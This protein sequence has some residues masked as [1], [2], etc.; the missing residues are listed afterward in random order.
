MSSKKKER[1]FT[2]TIPS[3]F[4]DCFVK[5]YC[6]EYKVT[7]VRKRA[8]GP[9]YVTGTWEALAKKIDRITVA[10]RVWYTIL[11]RRLE[12]ACEVDTLKILAGMK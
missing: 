8:K 1:T 4:E 11:M 5:G 6:E 3:H 10:D 7:S 12:K 9:I 2:V